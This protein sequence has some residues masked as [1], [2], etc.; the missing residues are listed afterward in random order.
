M[1]L[2]LSIWRRN[3]VGRALAVLILLGALGIE[4]PYVQAQ[5]PGRS[6]LIK[7]A[8]ILTMSG[9]P[10]DQ[11][12]IL[13]K[14]NRIAAIGRDLDA[15]LFCK[16]FDASGMTATPGLIDAWSALGRLGH[17]VKA[18]PTASAW[19]A[20]DSYDRAAL[21][22]ALSFGITTAYVAPGGGPGINGRGAIVR[23][24][25]G[26]GGMAGEL[27]TDEAAV[28]INLGSDQSSVARMKTFYAVRQ[29]FKKALTYRRS[30]EDYEEDL[31]EYL[32]KLKERREKE[33]SAGDKKDGGHKSK[34]KKSD[35]DSEAKGKDAPDKKK[36]KPEKSADGMSLWSQRTG[37][38][39]LGRR[40]KEKKSDK[41]KNGAK[42]KNGEEK[43]KEKE[44][45]ITKP[46]EP[47]RDP[48][49]EVLLKAIDHESVVR[50]EARRS[51][52]LLNALELA[53]EFGID[54]MLEG[55]TDAALV[56]DALADAEVP[57]VLG[58]P[59]HSM[60]FED[61]ATRRF[62]PDTSA[63]L[64][65]ASV[66]WTVGS[67]G[68]DPQ[69]ARFVG[70]FAQMMAGHADG[71]DHWLATVTRRA[72]DLLGLK[73]SGRLR[74]GMRADIVL[75]NSDPGE[76]DSRAQRVY[77]GG[78]LAFKAKPAQPKGGVR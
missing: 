39:S 52:D 25:P 8:R 55:A 13:I 21:R 65:E 33:A 46:T 3:A 60:A 18:D 78:R 48:S 47:D 45:E 38:G 6:V 36:P 51:A 70:L 35:K 34:D 22:E 77:V 59:I 62:N 71:Q 27:V 9:D 40:K 17:G 15:P 74:P 28:S 10:I 12:S 16:V 43:E 68:G 61:D 42:D 63:A 44:E 19:D 76:P 72:A 4:S 1:I 75:W 14:G 67:G 53:E 54:I 2:D 58:P 32:E 66:A 5:L 49:S 31:K 26:K 56:V 20:F 69:A 11:G 50:I 37:D 23:L 41:E 29:A 57:V 64:T 24:L 7:N 73:R 30:L